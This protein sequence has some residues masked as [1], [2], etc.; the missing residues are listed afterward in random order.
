MCSLLP[1]NSQLACHAVE[2]AVEALQYCYKFGACLRAVLLFRRGGEER[3]AQR[4]YP[5][6]PGRAR[7]CRRRLPCAAGRQHDDDVR[8]HIPRDLLS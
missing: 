1:A 4:L 8:H 6:H 3:R 2:P 5:A 7:V